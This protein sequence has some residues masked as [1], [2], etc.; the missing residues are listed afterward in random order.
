MP[1][2]GTNSYH[3]ALR[4]LTSKRHRFWPGEDY[5]ETLDATLIKVFS[6]IRNQTGYDF[7]Y[8]VTDINKGKLV[9]LHIN[10][11]SLRD[12][13]DSI[14]IN[15]PLTYT[16]SDKIII[17]KSRPVKKITGLLPSG[18]NQLIDIRGRVTNEENDPVAGVS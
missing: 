18:G 8:F 13:L 9:T 4:L 16:I 17:V 6:E 5:P 12:V 1:G 10:E 7:L 11:A 14:F 15:Q 3:F 2:N